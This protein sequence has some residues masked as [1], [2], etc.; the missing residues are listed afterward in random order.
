MADATIPTEEPKRNEED[1]TGAVCLLLWDDDIGYLVPSRQILLDSDDLAYISFYRWRL[2]RV[3]KK[4]IWR[5]MRS[6]VGR[7]IYLHRQLMEFPDNLTVDHINRDSLD[8]RRSNLRACTVAEN[9]L[10]SAGFTGGTSRFKGVA[11]TKARGK[12]TVF[13]GRRGARVFVGAFDSEI[14]AARAY[15]EYAKQHFGPFAYLNPV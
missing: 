15:N 14:E 3:G 7:T 2:H 11:W 1:Y 4:R 10:N 13:G 6:S 9:N 8:N 12:W 5:I